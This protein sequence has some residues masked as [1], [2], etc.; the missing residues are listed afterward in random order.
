MTRREPEGISFEAGYRR[1]Q[2][3][4]E[5]VNSN[6]VPVDEMCD[7]FAEGKGLDQ[8]LTAYLAE[9]KSRV[10]AIERGDGVPAFRIVPPSEEVAGH[11]E[12]A[13]GSGAPNRVPPP[14][15]ADEDQ[16]EIPF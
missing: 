3:I 13:R 4:A 7:L 5:R 14:S 2:E 16:E 8:A 11:A 10:E 15:G 1:L 9:Q 6:E 12:E